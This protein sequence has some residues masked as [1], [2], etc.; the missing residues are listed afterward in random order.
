MKTFAL[1]TMVALS[2]FAATGAE[3]TP[4]KADA[5]ACCKEAANAPQC[6]E[7]CWLDIETITLEAANGD[8]IAQYTVAWLSDTGVNNTPKDPEKAKEMYSK[9][10]PGLEKAAK[11][12]NPT[13][14]RALA[15]MYANGKG[16]EKNPEKAKE[17]MSWCKECAEKKAAEIK[18]AEKS[19]QEQNQSSEM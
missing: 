18:A 10:L 14:C 7:Q 16:V 5:A 1:I 9:A 15:S 11:E 2:G 4:A 13:A 12:G 17:I 19:S 8:P 6:D 3:A